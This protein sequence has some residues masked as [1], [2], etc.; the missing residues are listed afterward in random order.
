MEKVLFFR[1]ETSLK[2]KISLDEII[3]ELEKRR[4]YMHKLKSDDLI[5]YFDSLSQFWKKQKFDKKYNLKNI[6]DYLLK[7]NLEESLSVSLHG[8]Y[9][10]LDDFY[11]LGSSF[12]LFHAQPRGIVVQWLSGNVSIL[13]LFSIFSALITKNVCLVK[14][15]SKGHE[16]L[17][18][19]LRTLG[20]IKTNKVDGKELIKCI[21]VVLIDR[22]DKK[23]QEKLSMAADVRIAWGGKEAIDS[24]I[25]LKKK[26]YCEDIILGPKY[27]YGVI[28]KSSLK[29]NIKD[30]TRR[31]A[32]DISVFDQYACSSPHT[33]FVEG[34]LKD[35]EIFGKELGLQLDFVNRAILPKG[36]IDEGKAMEIVSKRTEYELKGKVFASKGTDWT[37]IVTDEGGLASS[38]F[39]RVVFVKPISNILKLK[40]YSDRG[41][42][43]LGIEL[44]LSERKEVLDEITLKGIDRAPN[45]GYMTFFEYC[46]DGMFVFDRLVRWVTTYQNE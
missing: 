45:F 10:A 9:K 2:R 19:L 13:G 46:W 5:E 38:C 8:N 27:S 22:D 31:L 11:E 25:N 28:G 21:A 36:E 12:L 39:S 34:S 43:T 35:A 41:K 1:G 44:N 18:T 26:F 33:I 15:S 24:I 17:I 14:A 37:V 4:E 30:I 3:E 7:K 6:S 29:K 40:E 23:N 42:Q 20:S 32:V 16:T